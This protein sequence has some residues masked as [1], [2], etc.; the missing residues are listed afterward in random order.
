MTK[1]MDYLY[2]LKIDERVTDDLSNAWGRCRKGGK[3]EAEPALTDWEH[4]VIDETRQLTLQQKKQLKMFLSQM[5]EDNRFRM[6]QNA[7]LE[8][9]YYEGNSD[10]PNPTYPEGVPSKSYSIRDSAS[11]PDQKSNRK[12]DK[13][14]Q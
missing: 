7:G 14:S 2:Q 9:D 6:A 11:A 1:I 10:H 12:R 8:N 4:D 3:L 5:L 13:K